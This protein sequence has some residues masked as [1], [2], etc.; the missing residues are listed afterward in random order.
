[1]YTHRNKK[2]DTKHLKQYRLWQTATQPAS[3]PDTL[4]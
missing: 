1:M 2:K 4:T 3:H